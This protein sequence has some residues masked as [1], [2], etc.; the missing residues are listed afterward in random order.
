LT[1]TGGQQRRIACLAF[2]VF[3]GLKLEAAEAAPERPSM[4]GRELARIICS[5]CHVVASDQEFSPLLQT[6][7]PPFEEIANRPK[8]N[9][10]SLRRFIATTH[11]D[12]QTIPMT[13]PKLEL[14]EQDIVM[15]SKYIMSL[16]K[17]Q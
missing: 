15:I 7:A 14:T 10:K 9:E 4:S 8:T 6:S 16:R 17:R 1:Q 12:G 3:C 13:M 2:Y 5:D 11:W